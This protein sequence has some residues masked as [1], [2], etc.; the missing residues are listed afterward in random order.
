MEVPAKIGKGVKGTAGSAKQQQG[1]RR[2]EPAKE[3]ELRL[4][5]HR[6]AVLDEGEH[7]AAAARIGG[8]AAHV[9]DRACGRYHRQS[10]VLASGPL[11]EAR[12]QRV[13]L[14]SGRARQ[15]RGAQVAVIVS[16]AEG[17]SHRRDERSYDDEEYSTG[18]HLAAPESRQTCDRIG[19]FHRRFQRS[20]RSTFFFGDLPVTER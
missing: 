7:I 14:T 18:N 13:I 11:G 8:E 12:A 16:D 10:A 1:L 4:G 3:L 6:R 5:R 15:N 19:R 9:F 20:V 17:R 2:R